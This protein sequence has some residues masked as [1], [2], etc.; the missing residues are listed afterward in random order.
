MIEQ[1]RLHNKALIF[2]SA[3]NKSFNLQK[4]L[5]NSFIERSIKDGVD[6]ILVKEENS[7]DE[8]YLETIKIFNTS[9]IQMEVSDDNRKHYEELSK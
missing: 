9:I 7:N 5:I 4:G 2:E 1:C 3:T 8:S 6:G